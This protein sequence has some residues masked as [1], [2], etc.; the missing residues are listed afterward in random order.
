MSYRDY[1]SHLYQGEKLTQI[2][3]PNRVGFIYRFNIRPIGAVR[4]TQSAKWRPTP[5]AKRY[6]EWKSAFAEIVYR[7]VKDERAF[8]LV[9][10]E[11]AAWWRFYIAMPAS[12]SLRKRRLLAN[13]PC[14]SKP[15]WDN[16]A[17]AVYDAVFAEDKWTW[18]V[19]GSTIWTDR[20]EGYI[21]FHRMPAWEPEPLLQLGS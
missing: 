1:L 11:S 20:P 4:L 21:E 10:L 3:D 5:A 8:H 17:K 19:R 15:D 12:W 18:D 9:E 14:M 6:F 16:C 7:A 13:T 2:R